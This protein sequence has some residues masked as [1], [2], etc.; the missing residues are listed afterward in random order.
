MNRSRFAPTASQPEPFH[1]LTVC[2]TLESLGTGVTGLDEEEAKARLLKYGYNQLVEKKRTTVLNIF[3]R[4]F[5]DVFVLMLIGASLI[6]MAFGEVVDA[7]TVGAILLLMA[8]VGFVQDFRGEKALEAMKKMTASTARVLRGGQ[9]KIIPS[10]EVTV[11]DV[12]V[13]EEGDRVAADSRLIETAELRTS[14]AVLTGESTPVEKQTKTLE[15]EV[16][17][18]ERSNIVFY[19]TH[20]VRGRGKAVVTATGM[21]TEFGKIAE[22]IQETEEAETPLQRKMNRFS[23]SIAKFVVGISVV[24]FVLYLLRLSP[25]GRIELAFSEALATSV[26]LA[27]SAVPEGIPAITAVTLALGAKALMKRQA[28]IR[29]LSSTETLGSVTV[30]CSDKT[31]TLTKGEMTVRT[32]YVD[33]RLAE[34]S[35]TGYQPEG[36]FTWKSSEELIDSAEDSQGSL[37][38]LLRIGALCNNAKLR[39]Q[40]NPESWQVLGDPTEGALVIAAKK[41]GLD[42]ESLEHQMPRV[43]EI[44]FSSDRKMMTTIHQLEEQ[45]F[46]AYVK[47]APEVIVENSSNVLSRGNEMPLT[48]EQRAMLLSITEELAGNG[49]RVLGMAYKRHLADYAA[50]DSDVEKDLTFVGFQGMIDPPRPEVIEANRRCETA[51]I[52]TVM[53]TGDH[54]LTATAIAKEI[55][56]LKSGS[57][58]LTGIELDKLGDQEFNHIASNVSVYA[59]VSP[60]HKQ[61]IVKALKENGHI[62]AMTGDGVNDAPAMKNADIGIAMGITGTDVTKEASHMVLADDNFATIVRAVEFGRLIFDNIRKYTRFLIACNFDEL[63]LLTTFVLVG[64]PLPLLPPMIL[65]LNLATDGGPAVALSMDPPED[66]AMSRPPRNPKEGILQGMIPFIVASTVFQI[67][68]SVFVF[69]VETWPYVSTGVLIPESILTKARTAVFLQSVFY[70]LTVVWNCRSEKHG[71]WKMSPLKNKYLLFSVAMAFTATI[72]LPYIP[73]LQSAFHLAPLA[74]SDLLLAGLAGGLGLFALPEVFFR[75]RLWHRA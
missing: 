67:C 60:E 57:L 26:S 37:E 75:K 58:V 53:I 32:I 42:K 46:V 2:G 73:A 65:W 7:L 43:K 21:R 64:L 56:I 62:V 13:I 4:Q 35:G 38:L 24:I 23:K 22:L 17:V 11:G 12:L 70:E 66:D 74:L 6:S 39:H 14:E 16:P 3:F 20:V 45:H 25:D 49:L 71:F 68:G 19:G 50:I 59:R 1:A 40:T 47:G 18:S 36:K 55:G 54:K 9:E 29:R 27:I 44:P 69:F 48:G 34:V 72:L 28:I 15:R 31:G 61:R 52:K 5:K 10:T 30:I 51:G 63:L 33:N 41:A 8:V